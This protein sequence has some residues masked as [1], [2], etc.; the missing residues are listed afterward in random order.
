MYLGNEKKA[1]ETAFKKIPTY[2]KGLIGILTAVIL[3]MGLAAPLIFKVT[4]NATHLNMD[5][6]LYEEMV[7]PHLVKEDK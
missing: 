6:G 7:N 3:A 5:D 4:D 1:E 2:R